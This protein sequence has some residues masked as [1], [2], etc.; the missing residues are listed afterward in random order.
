MKLFTRLAAC[1]FALSIVTGCASRVHP[2][3]GFNRFE[4]GTFNDVI[5]DSLGIQFTA[6]GDFEFEADPAK[7]NRSI[8]RNPGRFGQEA[9][10]LERVLLYGHTTVEPFF[11]FYLSFESEVEG[12]PSKQFK[13]ERI[14][15]LDTVIQS[16]TMRILAKNEDL[17]Y[18][19]N[20]KR[21]LRKMLSTVT[22]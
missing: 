14:W 22:E 5:N 18:R 15:R 4:Q 10:Q 1:G 6:P 2:L 11:K 21:D 17:M 9:R 13:D 20:F 12:K 16:I 7:V 3:F 19:E 8:R